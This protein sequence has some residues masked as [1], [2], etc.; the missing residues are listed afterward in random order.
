MPQN[1]VPTLKVWKD[2][3]DRWFTT[4]STELKALDTAIDNFN[5]A[6]AGEKAAK[7]ALVATAWKNWRG[8]A[9]KT[10]PELKLAKRN[11][12]KGLQLLERALIDNGLIPDTYLVGLD[13]S[14]VMV[15]FVDGARE[16]EIGALQIPGVNLGGPALKSAIDMGFAEALVALNEVVRALE[17]NSP[18]TQT[19]VRL[20]F[21]TTSTAMVLTKFRTVRDHVQN[22]H[23]GLRVPV[24]I[25]LKA[26]DAIAAAA[27]KLDYDRMEFYPLYFDTEVMSGANT[28]M[29]KRITSKPATIDYVRKWGEF[30]TAKRNI[31]RE[32]DLL[33]LR[34]IRGSN[35]DAIAAK[36]AQ[37]AQLV[38]KRI[39]ELK[40]SES[41]FRTRYGIVIHEFTHIVLKT[42]DVEIDIPALTIDGT[43]VSGKCYGATACSEL[44][45]YDPEKA[46]KNA[47]NYRLLAETCRF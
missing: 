12:S 15:K 18:D 4:R 27:W 5:K 28:Y 23:R 42:E 11:G 38:T 35:R 13:L 37:L 14:R 34:D 39:D 31:K 41:D 19:L 40:K 36:K 30:D 24:E 17:A 20:W 33:E 46:L 2:A 32:I 6:L 1:D 16:I 9:R 26:G 45:A 8:K 44:A 22:I 7:R 43:K 25:E 10:N 47:D 29:F 3:T 21:G